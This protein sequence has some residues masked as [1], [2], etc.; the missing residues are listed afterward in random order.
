MY[1]EDDYYCEPSELECIL[2]DFQSQ[3]TE[4]LMSSVRNNLNAIK[5][6]NVRLKAENEKYKQRERDIFNEKT[7][8][9]YKQDNLKIEV[10]KEFYDTNIGDALKRYTEECEVWFADIKYKDKIQCDLCDANRKIRAIF[11]DGEVVEK[12]CECNEKISYYA[13]DTAII[14]VLKFNRKNS[15]YVSER[16]FYFSKTYSPS[17]RSSSYYDEYNEFKLYNVVDIFNEDTIELHENKQ[18]GER[19]GFKTQEE[20]QKYCDWLNRRI[21]DKFEK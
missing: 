10:E 6:E 19:I 9:K 12:T 3:M 17:K 21:N 20:C 2:S 7:S 15:R 14:Q 13:P 8:L 5:E 18:W 4:I 11:P 16:K 1:F